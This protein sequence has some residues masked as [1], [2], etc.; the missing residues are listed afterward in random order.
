MGK[1]SNKLKKFF[2]QNYRNLKIPSLMI[3]QNRARIYLDEYEGQIELEKEY[4]ATK[5]N[6]KNTALRK[7]A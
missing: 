4:M 1:Q 5:W 3:Y 7:L 6:L 2:K